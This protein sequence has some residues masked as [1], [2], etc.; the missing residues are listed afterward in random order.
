MKKV[1]LVF[2]CVCLGLLIFVFLLSKSRKERLEF[3]SSSC[4]KCSGGVPGELSLFTHIEKINWDKD[5]LTVKARIRE[6]CGYKNRHK[7]FKGTYE[8]D[9]NN[10]KL[11]VTARKLFNPAMCA[12]SFPVV[13]KIK[14]I[15]MDIY[16]VTLSS[17]GSEK[18]K[19]TFYPDGKVLDACSDNPT[20]NC[21][22]MYLRN[23]GNLNKKNELDS[24]EDKVIFE[25]DEYGRVMQ[26]Y[27]RF[28]ELFKKYAWLGDASKC[29]DYY[30]SLVER[31]IRRPELGYIIRYKACG[32][33]GTLR[34]SGVD[35]EDV[36]EKTMAGWEKADSFA[37]GLQEKLGIKIIQMTQDKSSMRFILNGEEF[38]YDARL[39]AIGQN[40]PNII[41][42]CYKNKAFTVGE[43]TKEDFYDRVA[44]FKKFYE[45]L[46]NDKQIDFNVLRGIRAD[47]DPVSQ[48]AV[49]E[50]YVTPG[51]KEI[52][53]YIIIHSKPIKAALPVW[54]RI[55]V[56]LSAKSVDVEPVKK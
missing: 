51:E 36:M 33:S 37:S 10:L 48:I 5:G 32:F 19:L 54:R 18:D 26:K 38:H 45:I 17:F 25:K 15:K 11:F 40:D 42:L 9:N 4:S 55:R 39:G 23:Y 44:T 31:K 35:F 13:F 21:F 56:D 30:F 12:C 2:V 7:A 1:L 16:N 49:F 22:L 53:D 43:I 3:S 47:Y 50:D 6:N 24:K 52:N 20:Y 14:G 8:L 46:K 34:E 27:P 28:L 29:H 41:E